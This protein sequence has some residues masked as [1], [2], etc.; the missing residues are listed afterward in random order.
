MINQPNRLNTEL[1][2]L[3][4]DYLPRTGPLHTLA[5]GKPNW[6]TAIEDDGLRVET[7]KSRATGMG[8]QHVPAWML[9]V[10]WE[11]LTTQGTLT[12]RELLAADDLNI[13]R[14][15]FVCAALACLPGVAVASLRPIT[16]TYDG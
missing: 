6:V 15:S 12:N 16:L 14:S 3:L 8:P 13:K 1:L 4:R 7:E 2:T 5:N 11:R 9:E 10:A